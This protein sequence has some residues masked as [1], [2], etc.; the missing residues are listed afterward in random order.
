MI[1]LRTGLNVSDFLESLKAKGLKVSLKNIISEKTLIFAVSIEHHSKIFTLI[2][3]IG[4]NAITITPPS[5]RAQFFIT[6]VC[7]E[8]PTQKI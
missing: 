3:E 8:K 5:L 7:I 4:L 2:K 6:G 1:S